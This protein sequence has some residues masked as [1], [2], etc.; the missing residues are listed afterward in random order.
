MHP[1]QELPLMLRWMTPRLAR[2]AQREA[3]PSRRPALAA[4]RAAG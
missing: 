2:A 1:G 4:R 3:G